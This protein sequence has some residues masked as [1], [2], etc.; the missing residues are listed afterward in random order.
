MST[1]TFELI[2]TYVKKRKKRKKYTF[3]LL[4]NFKTNRFSREIFH[5]CC[6][7]MHSGPQVCDLCLWRTSFWNS[8]ERGKEREERKRRRRKE[9]V[10]GNEGWCKSPTGPRKEREKITRFGILR[11]GQ[12]PRIPPDPQMASIMVYRGSWELQWQLQLHYNN[13]LNHEIIARKCFLKIVFSE[14]PGE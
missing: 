1:W 14:P 9:R 3:D 11:W 2:A 7:P 4:L 10:S 5:I 13:C 12:N 6:A 8:K